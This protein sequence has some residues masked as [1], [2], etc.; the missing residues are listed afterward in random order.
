M[1]SFKYIFLLPAVLLTFSCELV[2]DV[3][4]PEAE[5]Q[6]AAHCFLLNSD[7][8]LRVSAGNT[9]G[10]L[11]AGDPERFDDA[12]VRLWEGEQLLLTFQSGEA[13]P[14]R[15]AQEPGRTYRLEVEYPGLETIS[16]EQT[17]PAPVPVIE[18]VLNVNASVD[19][20]GDDVHLLNLTIDDPAGVDN[21][22][23]LAVVGDGEN[24]WNDFQL[25]PLEDQVVGNWVYN[26]YITLDDATFDGKEQELVFRFF[27]YSDRI[28]EASLIWRTITPE[29]YRYLNSFTNQQR[30]EDNPFAEPAPIFSNMEGGLG[31]FAI[32]WEE[33]AP[34]QVK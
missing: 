15:P 14:F 29:R 24:G 18:A 30:A 12:T 23:E 16:A 28:E 26:D 8:T 11:E 21:Y 1:K 13:A 17:M 7:S 3:D 5:T 33:R 32:G 20:E 9:V 19:Q 2:L 4:L 22:Y 25:R 31:I 6:L 34:V 27:S 10:L